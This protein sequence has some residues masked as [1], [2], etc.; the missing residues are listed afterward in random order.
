MREQ[1]TFDDHTSAVQAWEAQDERGGAIA[2][3]ADAG[4]AGCSEDFLVHVPSNNFLKIY[5]VLPRPWTSR[6]TYDTLYYTGRKNYLY[7][8]EGSLLYV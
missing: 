2:M 3:H 5:E 8:F 1:N 4:L 6:H 7:Y